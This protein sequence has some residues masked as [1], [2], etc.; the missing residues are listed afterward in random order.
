[1]EGLCV[2]VCGFSSKTNPYIL[3]FIDSEKMMESETERENEN[4][5]I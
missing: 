5:F 3:C 1:M 2:C 4:V